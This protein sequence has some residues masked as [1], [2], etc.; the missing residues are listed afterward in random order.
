MGQLTPSLA[1]TAAREKAPTVITEEPEQQL[2]TSVEA[3]P[4]SRP[5]SASPTDT[6]ENPTLFQ[7]IAF[8]S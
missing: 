8:S 7:A 6:E 1:M 2:S 3:E 4:E 5:E